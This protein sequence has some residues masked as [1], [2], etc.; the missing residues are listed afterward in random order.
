M[1]EEEADQRL[2]L[3]AGAAGHGCT[4]HQVRLTALPGQDH[5][6][7]RQEHHEQGRVLPLGERLERL[8]RLGRQGAGQRQAAVVLHWRVG[9][10]R[11]QLEQRRSALEMP[12]PVVEVWAEGLALLAAVLPRGEVGVLDREWRQG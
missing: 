7:R 2:D 10:V 11:R 5:G 9:P 1:V 4:D 12:A 6:V 3:C 8:A